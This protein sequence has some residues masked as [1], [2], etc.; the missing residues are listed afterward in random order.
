MYS[1]ILL[2]LSGEALAGA[3]K[4]GILDDKAL[5]STA[6]AIKGIVDLGTQVSIVVGAGNICRGA[7]IEKIGI[8][9]VTGDYMGML[10][11]TIN[12]FG[13][14]EA[15]K[16]LGIKAVVLSAIKIETFCEKY[17]PKLAEKYM[18]KG[19]IVLFAAGTG[20]PYFTTDTCAT[21]RAIETKCEAI[22]VAKNGV[23]GVYDDDPRTN[24]KAKMYKEVTCSEIIK[25]DLKVMD[26]TAIKM[27]IDKDIDVRVFNM[28]KPENFIKVTRGEN[29]GTV[30]KKG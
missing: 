5:L 15:L 6:K 18:K 12:C 29:V 16:N 1:R 19:F 26:L 30:V 4:S 8:N 25:K 24:K 21:M 2:K 28:A 27:L 22:L 7:M 3:G 10:G 17:S 23:D 9:R 13:L 14:S 11:T 20:K